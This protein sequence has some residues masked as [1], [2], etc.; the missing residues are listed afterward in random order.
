MN[1][2]INSSNSLSSEELTRYRRHFTLPNVGIEG[3]KRLKSARV[4]CVGAG[5][6]GSPVLLYLAAA[7]VGTIGII[8]D[9]IIE[10][11]NLQRQV[12]Y[13]TEDIKQKKA[14]A[15]KYR[16]GKLNPNINIVC[17][18]ERLIKDNALKIIKNYD[19]VADG[20]DNFASRYL[21]NDACFH[22]KKPNVYASIFQFEGQCSV[23]N[24]NDGPCYRCLFDS[25]PPDGLIPNCAEGGV[26]GVLP[27]LVGT[28][29]AIEIIKLILN[30][31]KSLAGRLLTINA[32]SMSFQ[33][34]KIQRHPSCR[35]CTFHQPFDTLPNHDPI[36]CTNLNLLEITV[37]ELYELKQRNASYMLIDVREPYEYSICNLGGNLIPLSELGNQLTKLDKNQ[38]YIVHCKT[39]NRSLKAVKIMHD[40][41]F[42]LVKNLYGGILAWAKEIDQNMPTY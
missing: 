29:Q 4:L 3:Q 26:L 17:Y 34:F 42:S 6:L 18:S 23:F 37:N 7:G 35:L 10:P 16:L 25:P 31:G 32:L 2:L 1:N 39:G 21:V 11:S 20:T 27:G 13:T 22:L 28:I 30:I 36:A 24:T 14:E 19:I 40:A 9:D 8:D 33:E 15:A 5:G 12:L 41:G 38:S